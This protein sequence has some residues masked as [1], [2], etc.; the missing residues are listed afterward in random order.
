[1]PNSREAGGTARAPVQLR[2]AD[3]L[4]TGVGIL[5]VGSAEV[6]GAI[7]VRAHRYLV[8]VRLRL[9]LRGRGRGRVRGRVF[10]LGLGLR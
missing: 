9:R 3:P 2:V 10:G 8:R 5:S 1:M 4:R 7:R 6:G